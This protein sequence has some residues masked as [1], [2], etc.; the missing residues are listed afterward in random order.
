MIYQ[1]DLSPQ[2]LPKT[3]ISGV[4]SMPGT[5]RPRV[6]TFITTYRR[7]GPLLDL[8]RDLCDSAAPIELSLEI[9]EDGSPGQEQVPQGLLP[10]GV[11]FH[12]CKH[13]G[14]HNYWR[15][16]SRA[17]ESCRSTNADYYCML[18]DDLVLARGFFDQLL[19]IWSRI[20]D[21]DLVCLN[22]RLD[23]EL[24][25]LSN[26]TGVDPT[27][28]NF[29]DLELWRTQWTDCV[30]FGS[31][32]M[33]EKLDFRIHSIDPDRWEANPNASSGVGAQ[34]SH[35]L[36]DAGCSIYQVA[37][38][39]VG[40]GSLESLMNPGVREKRPLTAVVGSPGA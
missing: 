8:V 1:R 26:W 9:Y 2:A 21:A 4:N 37:S 7:P 22:P 17:L 5:D 29:G 18:Q 39:L 28:V 30:F 24:T 38:S 6:H 31:R 33:L 15:L 12:R 14:K 16:V 13:H 3:T 40:H 23:R 35:R 25:G 10:S 36:H 11:R 19:E 20:D 34:I 32:T 27:L